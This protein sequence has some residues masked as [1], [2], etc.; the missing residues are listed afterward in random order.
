MIFHYHL[1]RKTPIGE[2]AIVYTPLP[3]RMHRIFL[4]NPDRK[5]WSAFLPAPFFR[6][7]ACSQSSFWSERI[8]RYLSGS[9]DAPGPVP[10]D[11][12]HMGYLTPL[13]AQVLSATTGI[14]FGQT[15]SYGDIAKAIG[16][17]KAC[18]FVGTALSRNPFPILIPCHRIIRSDG[19]PGRFG[20]G[21]EMKKWLLS[22]EVSA[23]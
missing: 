8:V 15:A 17:P 11:D 7:A 1:V 6:P 22:M 21:E 23:T 14:S 4:P 2:L 19:S 10:W 9:S 13:Q 20:G 12:L 5:K 3:F 16:R 18:R